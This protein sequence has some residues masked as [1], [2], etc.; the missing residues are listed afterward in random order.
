MSANVVTANIEIQGDIIS[1]G[2]I[3]AA[4]AVFTDRLETFTPGGTFTLT[5][6][7]VNDFLANDPLGIDT[8]ANSALSGGVYAAPFTGSI[9]YVTGDRHGSRGAP[10]YWSGTEWRY[11]SDDANVTI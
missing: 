6:V 10:A 11:F 4:N 1:D 2:D 8:V 7:R 9:V 5:S 3:K